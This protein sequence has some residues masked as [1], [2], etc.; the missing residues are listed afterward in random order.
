MFMTV[1]EE[2]LGRYNEDKVVKIDE[3]GRIE[4][5]EEEE[6]DNRSEGEIN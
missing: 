1:V 3:E 6:I 2:M 5:E 4:E